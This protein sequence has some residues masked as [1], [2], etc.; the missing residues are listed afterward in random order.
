MASKPVARLRKGQLLGY[1]RGQ[2]MGAL[3]LFLV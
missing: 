2:W 3:A 1:V